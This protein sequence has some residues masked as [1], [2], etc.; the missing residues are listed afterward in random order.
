MNKLEHLATYIAKIPS[1][2]SPIKHM[3]TGLLESMELT[4]MKA[5]VCGL[6]DMAYH[7]TSEEE[8]LSLLRGIRELLL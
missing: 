3:L 1:E 5:Y 6:Y 4:N 8:L 2:Y 7:L